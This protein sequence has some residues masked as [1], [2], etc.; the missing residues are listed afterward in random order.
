LVFVSILAYFAE[1]FRRLKTQ[2]QR[3][4]KNDLIRRLGGALCVS[5]ERENLRLEKSRLTKKQNRRKTA[6]F[7]TAP[8]FL[9][10]KAWC[11]DIN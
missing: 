7:S 2:G 10:N 1:I 4:K 6:A 8:L 11:Q 9:F 5:E 3:Q